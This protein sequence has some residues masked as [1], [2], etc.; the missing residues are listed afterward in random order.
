MRGE[1]SKMET[2]K[3]E[4]IRLG[5]FL[6]L[7]FV[8]IVGFVGYLV[9][10]KVRDQ[11]ISYFTVFSESVQGLSKDARVMLNGIDVG[12]V[13]K[14]QIDQDNLNNVVVWFEVSPETPV[15]AGTRVQM[16]SG[17][18]LTGNRYLILSGGEAN[19]PNLPDESFV[20]PGVNRISEITGQ[21]ENLVARIEV[22]IDNLN[23]IL[24]EKN[25]KKISR[26]LSNFEEASA[27]SKQLM[28]NGNVLVNNGNALLNTG[29]RF[30]K[31]M[32][33][34]LAKL[35]TTLG[36]LQHITAEVDDAHLAVEIKKTLGDIQAKMAAL[37]TK[38]MNEELVRTLR[39]VEAMSKRMD[40]FLY[41]NQTNF[42]AALTQL[43]NILENLNEFSQKIKNQPSSLIRGPKASER[44]K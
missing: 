28:A 7:C 44:E 16:T 9:G 2:T 31:S 13:R 25:A 35:D 33:A 1:T 34:P 14:I 36:S 26:A 6:L 27:G 42:G 32:D 40:V 3:A 15:K 11:K 41:K 8:G 10:E 23:N 37:D 17:I 43:N 22:L 12:H 39:S 21:A 4:R 5:L 29:S 24:S 20:E 38:Q 19:E 30:I 18:S